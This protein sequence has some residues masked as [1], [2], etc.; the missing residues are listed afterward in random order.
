MNP[1]LGIELLNKRPFTKK[2]YMN[3]WTFYRKTF[4][5]QINQIHLVWH[6]WSSFLHK[7]TFMLHEYVFDSEKLW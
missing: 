4:V 2:A 1:Q 6:N 7:M 5:K 3:N